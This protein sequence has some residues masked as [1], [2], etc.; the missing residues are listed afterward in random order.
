MMLGFST[1]QK[2]GTS[3]SWVV[4]GSAA[5]PLV[6]H[7]QINL[8]HVCHLYPVRDADTGWYNCMTRTSKELEFWKE[9]E[10]YKWFG[11]SDGVKRGTFPASRGGVRIKWPLF[12]KHIEEM[13]E[14]KG[15]AYAAKWRRHSERSWR[16]RGSLQIQI[17]RSRGA[18]KVFERWWGMQVGAD[19][20]IYK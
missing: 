11:N 12:E 16:Y 17:R 8:M 9:G 6:N 20:G 1:A 2:V 19:L 15:S 10:S 14:S 13:W 3:N 5:V 4:Q 7:P 18:V